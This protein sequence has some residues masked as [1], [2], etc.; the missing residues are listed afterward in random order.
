[1]TRPALLAALL[2]MGA[3]AAPPPPPPPGDPRLIITPAASS[4]RYGLPV[5]ARGADGRLRVNV[6]V[7]NPHEAD[8]PLRVQ[9]DWL[10]GTGRPIPTLLSRPAFRSLARGTVTTID[11]DAPHPRAEDFRMTFDTEN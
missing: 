9:T 6:D 2:L 8:F 4:L 3:C 11:A 5:V 10:D 1:M 7:V